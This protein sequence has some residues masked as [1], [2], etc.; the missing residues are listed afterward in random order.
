[1]D[2]LRRINSRLTLHLALGAV[3]CVLGSI[4]PLISAQGAGPP[5]TQPGMKIYIN[6]ETGELLEQP[7]KGAEAMVTPSVALPRPE[8]VESPEPGGGVMVDV[9]KRFQTPLHVRM[10]SDGKPVLGHGDVPS[11]PPK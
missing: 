11:A 9:R 1:M 10:G 4:A 6:P 8:Q 2:K 7:P 3:T 5:A